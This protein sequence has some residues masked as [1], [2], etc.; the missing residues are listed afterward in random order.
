[1][2]SFILYSICMNKRFFLLIVVVIMT[3]A[4]IDL[5]DSFKYFDTITSKFIK[6]ESKV[7]QNKLIK[8]QK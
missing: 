6:S 7:I 5:V 3:I 8:T 1:M 4:Y 2:Y